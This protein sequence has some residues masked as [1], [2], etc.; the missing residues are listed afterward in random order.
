ML[1][2]WQEVEVISVEIFK[3]EF[4]LLKLKVIVFIFSV[5]LKDSA[6]AL[7]CSSPAVFMFVLGFLIKG[8]Y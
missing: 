8:W 3:G 2:F 1:I 4:Y 6:F 5:A 7:H